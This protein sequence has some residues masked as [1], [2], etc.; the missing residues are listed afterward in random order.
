MAKVEVTKLRE[1]LNNF[2]QDVDTEGK[3]DTQLANA[4]VD[5]HLLKFQIFI[6]EEI[7]QKLK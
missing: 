2:F 6:E 7:W 5:V 1:M 3:I 4:I